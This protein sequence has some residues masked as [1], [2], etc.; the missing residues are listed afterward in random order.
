MQQHFASVNASLLNGLTFCLKRF[1]DSFPLA[2][3]VMKMLTVV[4]ATLLSLAALVNATK[5]SLFL[6]AAMSL[7]EA[8]ARTATEVNIFV[9]TFC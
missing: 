9:T 4:M 7:Y 3:F 1:R 8:K 5:I 2:K 6:F